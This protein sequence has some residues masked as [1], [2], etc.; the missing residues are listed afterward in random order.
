VNTALIMWVIISQLV[1]LFHAVNRL[2]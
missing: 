2:N 1:E